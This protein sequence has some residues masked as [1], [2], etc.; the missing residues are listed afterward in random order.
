MTEDTDGKET[1]T[2]DASDKKYKFLKPGKGT[3]PTKGA[4]VAVFKPIKD[5]GVQQ[6]I[7]HQIV[8]FWLSEMKKEVDKEKAEEAKKKTEVDNLK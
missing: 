6:S 2:E 4:K 7:G 8:D 3:G 1:C 5:D